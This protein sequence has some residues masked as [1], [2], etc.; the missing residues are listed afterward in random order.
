MTLPLSGPISLSMIN[1]EIGKAANSISSLNDAGVRALL[2][3]PSGAISLSDGYGKSGAHWDDQSPMLNGSGNPYSGFGGL[4]WCPSLS[5]YAAMSTWGEIYTSPTGAV[6]TYKPDLRDKTTGTMRIYSG[7]LWT[8][9]ALIASMYYNASYIYSSPNGATFTA[10]AAGPN[11]PMSAANYNSATGQLVV[12]CMG[13]YLNYSTN[14]GASWTA[15]N[16]T[17][18][19]SY[20]E[21][22]SI[23]NNGT[24][25]LVGCYPDGLTSTTNFTAWTNRTPPTFAVRNVM[26]LNN[27]WI[28]TGS[29]G[30]LYFSTN[31]TSWTETMNLK[32][33]FNG[34]S[35]NGLV[36]AW[37][38]TYWLAGGLNGQLAKST[39]LVNWTSVGWL[40]SLSGWSNMTIGAICWAN[41]KWIALGEG[42]GKVAISNAGS[43]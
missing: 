35:S 10:A 2:G 1:T 18:P 21:M 38:G 13:G 25:W 7:L 43:Q 32:N 28:V 20:N 34:T 6:W 3:K 27:T 16:G 41:N 22:Q 37:N 26:F 5:L 17:R 30:E 4:V 42:N 11:N 8:G 14:I 31:L 33:I 23:A 29:L 40:S 9:S 15:T 19:N 36:L 24:T 12:G 39:D